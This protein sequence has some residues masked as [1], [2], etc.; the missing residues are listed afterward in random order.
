MKHD[1]D[2]LGPW[3]LGPAAE[4]DQLL[5][6]LVLEFVRD[7]VYWRRNF[8]SEDGQRISPAAKHAPDYLEFQDRLRSELYRLSADLKRAIPFFHPATSGDQLADMFG[9]STDPAAE[10]CAWGGYL[11]SVFR[12]PDGSFR[13]RE[14]V[15]S[16]FRHF[17]SSMVYDAFLSV[18]EAD[19]ITVDPHKLG[20]I[21]YAAGAYV[22]RNREVTDFIAQRAAYVPFEPDSNL[23]CLALNPEGNE[24]LAPMNRFGRQ[25]FGRMKVDAEQP[26]SSRRS[27]APTRPSPSPTC[28]GPRPIGSSRSSAWI[29]TRSSWFRSDR[30]ATPIT[31]TCSATPS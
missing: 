3:F 22:A 5:E 11:T 29:G 9:Y 30:T 28:R 2:F 23:I 10:P 6:E 19:S 26:C 15:A 13:A 18:R 17:P 24:D 25:V 7:H 31:C 4:N 27:S 1:I 14:D 20:Y 21:P 12:A 16:G 8:H